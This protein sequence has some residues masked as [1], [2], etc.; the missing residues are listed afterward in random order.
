MR[1]RRGAVAVSRRIGPLA[2]AYALHATGD[3]ETSDEVV[4][5]ASQSA[6]PRRLAALADFVVAAERF[7]LAEDLLSRLGDHPRHV[8]RR[9]RLAVKMGRTLPGDDQTAS[10]QQSP[11]TGRVTRIG[12]THRGP[13]VN[14][15]V[16]SV[17]NRVLHVVTNSLPHTNAGYTQ[18]TQRIVRAQAEAG[19]DP[20]VVT[21]LGHPLA[22][23][24]FDPAACVEVEGVPY[25]RLVPWTAPRTPEQALRRSVRLASRLVERLRPEVLHAASNHRNAEVALKLG[26][27]YG[28]PVVY[29]V[30]GF[31]EDSWLSRDPR[32]SREDPY[33]L[34]ERA[35]ETDCMRRA[36]VV[37]TLGEAMREE[38]VS[39]GV[40]ADK[41]MVVPNA[42]AAARGARE[43]SQESARRALGIDPAAFVV[44]T[45]TTCYGFEGLDTLLDAV[46]LL[47]TPAPPEPGAAAQVVIVGD[48]PELP[49]L[50]A[51]AAEL[52]AQDWVLLPGR[53]PGGEVPRYHAAFDAFAVPRRDERVCRLVTPLKPVEAMAAGLP[54]VASDLPAL[55]ELVEHSVSGLLTPP[56]DPAS[57]ADALAELAY[58]R[59]RRAAMGEAARRQVAERTWGATAYHYKVVYAAASSRLTGTGQHR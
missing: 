26:E 41:V 35:L 14:S 37:V 11:S 29:E 1:A 15:G 12:R 38:I 36:A 4:R 49:A 21:R 56:E 34:K 27:L 10:D 43:E 33:Y 44:G 46:A 13:A 58:G 22:Q 3:H 40:D 53:V 47:R 45:T 20:H 39:R 19:L 31:L 55:A 7:D 32:R 54:V 51:R 5:R 23:G 17:N 25:H 6:S 50:R 24:V 16:P 42:V 48:G 18:R 57:L 9:R 2:L 30:R 8:R 52:G 59:S 28:L